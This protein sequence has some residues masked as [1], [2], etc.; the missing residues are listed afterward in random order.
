MSSWQAES[1][2]TELR[3]FFS[4]SMPLAKSKV[5]IFLVNAVS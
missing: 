3:K 1:A 2:A 4:R 5:R